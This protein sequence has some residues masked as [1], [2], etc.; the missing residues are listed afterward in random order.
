MAELIVPASGLHELLS[1]SKL[2]CLVNA[3]LKTLQSPPLSS[4]N[5]EPRITIDNIHLILSCATCSQADVISFS[6]ID[7]K[8]RFR[9]I[10][11]LWTE[12]LSSDPQTV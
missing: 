9:K 4:E 5:H 10:Q 3:L 2:T 11:P 12:S 7:E 8:L 1:Y 6:I